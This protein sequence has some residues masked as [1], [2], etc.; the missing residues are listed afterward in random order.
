MNIL[1]L[2]LD[3]RDGAAVSEVA[4]NFGLE[5]RQARDLF[6]EIVP[7]IARGMQRNTRQKGGMEELAGALGRGTHD[8][9]LDDLSNLSNPATTR[10]GDDILGRVFGSR[11]GSRNVAKH[12]GSR[13]GIDPE[14]I[15]KTLP[16]VAA[17]AMGSLSKQG[18]SVDA[19]PR[20]QG[21]TGPSDIL[22]SVLAMDRDGSMLDD[23]IGM[24]GKIMR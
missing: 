8:R 14:L 10:D 1:D 3:A 17:I 7:P 22:S 20:G 18:K 4:R 11:G 19:A 24:A 15:R 23:L 13:T 9:S 6:S 21:G 2:V 16:V 5:E 12:A